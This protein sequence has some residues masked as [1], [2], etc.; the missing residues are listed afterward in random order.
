[1]M[2]QGAAIENVQVT[3]GTSEANYINIWSLV[4]QTDEIVLM[5]PN[6]MQIWGISRGFGGVVRP[7]HL[8]E[9]T[10]WRPDLDEL[11]RS[12]NQKTKLIAV[13]NPN[14]PTGYIL[15]DDEMRAIVE[16]ARRANAWLLCDEVYQGA[17]RE[18]PRTK[19]FW[20]M[21]DKVIVTNG[22]SKAYG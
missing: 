15:T 13:C 22:L 2:Y 14:N 18:R 17:E 21:Y 5:L 11:Q 6:Y 9:E 7:F 19:S 12:V 16:I 3:N 1:A 8:R 10:G 20:G 4:D